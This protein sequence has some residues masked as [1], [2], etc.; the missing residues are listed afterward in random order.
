MKK[1]ALPRP[2]YLH[3]YQP[4]FALRCS[5]S[6]LGAAH[7]AVSTSS[8]ALL[9]HTPFHLQHRPETGQVS[10]ECMALRPSAQV[11]SLCDLPQSACVCQLCP[12]SA[13]QPCLHL[14]PRTTQSSKPPPASL[15][16]LAHHPKLL[17]LRASGLSLWFLL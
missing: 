13:P 11:S 10:S 3:N 14:V 7:A 8:L 1:K 2:R 15:Q 5:K 16:G 9:S 4:V 17:I 12:S 6:P